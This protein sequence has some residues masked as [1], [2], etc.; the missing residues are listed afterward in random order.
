MSHHFKVLLAAML[1]L[2]VGGVAAVNVQAADDFHCSVSPC[3]VTLKL[4]GTGKT[5]HQ[6]YVVENESTTETVSFTCESLRG[7]AEAKGNA[8]TELTITNVAYDNCTINGSAGVVID[9]NGCSYV[10]RS[11][12]GTTDEAEGR[13]ECPTGKKT[14]VTYNGCVLMLAGGF[15][16]K[17]F[18]YQT[19][20]ASPNREVTATVNHVTAPASQ[21]TFVGTHAQCLINPEQKTVITYITGNTLLTGESTAGAMADAWYE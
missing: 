21:V 1:V 6:V 20:G 5:A 2:P 17:G 18:G 14:E 15:G 13:L 3:R 9:A 19:V 10:F 11:L 8:A 12:N 4:D 16:S 7:E